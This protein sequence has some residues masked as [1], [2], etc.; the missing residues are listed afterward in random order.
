[1]PCCRQEDPSLQNFLAQ[2]Q[3]AVLLPR[4]E[5]P[6]Q[7]VL[8]KHSSA[9]L[10]QYTAVC[11]PSENKRRFNFFTGTFG[12]PL[13]TYLTSVSLLLL[14]GL[15]GVFVFIFNA[16]KMLSFRPEQAA[17]LL[18][19]EP[20]GIALL[21]GSCRVPSAHCCAPANKSGLFLA[22]KNPI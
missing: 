17:E 18:H 14:S 3:G 16:L 6:L 22:K 8:F 15:K 9:V 12:S 19:T 10:A 4:G 5:N 13:A 1:M 11:F 7:K 21:S 20:L 2:K